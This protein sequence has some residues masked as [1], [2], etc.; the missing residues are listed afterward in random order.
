[1]DKIAF[2]FSGQG[3]Q[4]PGMGRA[5][6][7][8]SEAAARVYA[9]AEEIR[10][11]TRLQCAEAAMELLS[12]TEN[13][14]PC[15]FCVDLA[16]AEALRARGVR[17][18]A[19]AGFSLGEIPALAFAGM[20]DTS[21]A[22]RLV[23]VRAQAMQ[24]CAEARSGGMVAAMGLTNGAIEALCREIGGLYP[25][26]YNCPGQLVVAGPREDLPAFLQALKR[27]G[28]KGVALPVSG[29]F[30]S[31]YMEAAREA[32]R[33]HLAHVALRAPR[34][35]VYANATGEPY[36]P[37]YADLIAR[38]VVSP[39]RWQDTILR[40]VADGIS[41]FI[42]VG[43]GKTLGGLI[44]KTAPEALVLQVEDPESL[45]HVLRWWKEKTHV[46]Q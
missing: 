5:L 21:E 35:P 12:R 14:Q 13:A 30:H 16:A 10:P 39:V 9:L 23:C 42:E 4:T 20:L 36:A 15:L 28:G 18:D 1:M 37:P 11:G 27:S 24:A 43:V 17:P 38:Q 31:P 19:V 22:F 8:Q 6:A 33:A 32:L 7:E 46:D 3:A 25:A 45:E 29:A 34:F 40:M 2:V 44:R 26:N 41:A